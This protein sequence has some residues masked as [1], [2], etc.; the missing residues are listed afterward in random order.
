M[1]GLPE[2]YTVTL[3]AHPPWMLEPDVLTLKRPDGS[4]VDTFVP[5]GHVEAIKRAA[6]RDYRR[7]ILRPVDGEKPS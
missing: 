3:G 4:V 5:G 1:G 2:G 7:R 6:W